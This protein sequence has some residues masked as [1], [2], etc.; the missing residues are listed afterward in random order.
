[1]RK[2]EIDRDLF[3]PLPGRAV[4]IGKCMAIKQIDKIR[5]RQLQ[6]FRRFAGG[7]VPIAECGQH[8]LA[9]GILC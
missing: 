4:K 3:G 1:M 6:Q 8:Q 2:Q 7:N 5:F 9:T